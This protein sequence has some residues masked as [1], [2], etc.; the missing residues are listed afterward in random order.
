M[1]LDHIDGSS[2]LN[3]VM[4]CYCQTKAWFLRELYFHRIEVHASTASNF[5]IAMVKVW[6][7]QDYII[8]GK[9]KQRLQTKSLVMYCFDVTAVEL[10]SWNKQISI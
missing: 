5:Y 1:F 4:A 10:N 3:H 2:I 9:T 8:F 7:M 6:L